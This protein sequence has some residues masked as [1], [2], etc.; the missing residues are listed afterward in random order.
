M[1]TRITILTLVVVW[2]LMFLLTSPAQGQSMAVPVDTVSAEYDSLVLPHP[3]IHPSL[4]SIHNLEGNRLSDSVDYHLSSRTLIILNHEQHYDQYFVIH[5]KP[6]SPILARPATWV[7]TQQVKSD[8]LIKSLPGGLA[9]DA[10]LPAWSSISYSGHFGRGINIGNN[11][12]TTLNSNFDLQ[13]KGSLPHGIEVVGSLSDNSI[14]IQPEGNSQR[15]QEFDKVFIQLRKDNATLIAGDHEIRNPE[16]YF[17]QYYKKTKGVFA[18]YDSTTPTGWNQQSTINY[19]VSKGK[20]KR[21]TIESEEGNQGPYRLDQT[22][23]NLFVVV[24]AGTERVYLDGRLLQRGELNDYTI[25]YNLGEITFTPRIY[26][27][28]T[29]RIIVEYEFAEQ[30]YLRSLFAGHSTWKKNNWELG[31]HVYSE[32]DGKNAYQ[33]NILT[34]ENE[35]ILAEVGDEVENLN[36]TSVVPWDGGFEEGVVLYQLIDT[37][38]FS[39]VLDLV[40]QPVDVPLYTA[41]F[42]FVG[43]GNGDYEQKGN[44]SNGEVYQWVAPDPDGSSNG[45]YAPITRLQAPQKQQMFGFDLK[46]SWGPNQENQI[47]SEWSLTNEDLN[48]FSSLDKADNVGWAQYSGFSWG[49]S[50]DSARHQ[51]FRVEGNMEW[52]NQTYQPVSN[53]RP[54]EFNR[55]WNYSAEQ[56]TVREQLYTIRATY[57]DRNFKTGYG[58]QNFD[59]DSLYSGQ[60]HELNLDWTPGSFDISLYESLTQSRTSLTGSLFSRPAATLTWHGTESG[61]LAITTGYQGE[62]NA[63]RSRDTD[64][65]SS[66]SMRFDRI[67]TTVDWK[68][69]HSLTLSSRTDYST[70]ADGFLPSF[71]TDDLQMQTGIT[72]ETGFIRWITTLRHLKVLQ[73]QSI[74]QDDQKGW[75]ILG[76]MLFAQKWFDDGWRNQGEIAVSNGKE[77]RRQFQYIK[78]ETGQ[79]QYKYVDVNNDSIQ[80]LNEFFPAIYPDE[81]NYIRVSTLENTLISTFNYKL[82]WAWNIDLAKWTTHDFWSKWSTDNSIQIENKQQRTGE[83]SLWNIPDTALVSARQNVLTNL[84]FNRNG[85]V[86]QEH[87]GYWVRKQK[88]FLHTGSESFDSQE[89]FSK[90]TLLFSNRIN[91][92]IEL[93]K[94]ITHQSATS[95]AERNFRI[96]FLQG[97]HKLRWMI[98]RT[99]QLEYKVGI[100]QG[101]EREGTTKSSTWTN[102]LSWQYKPDLKWSAH[103]TVDYSRVKF[104]SEEQNISLEQVM[105]EGLRPGGNLLWELNVQ[106]RLPNNLVV[107]LRYH[108]RKTGDASVVHTGSIQANLLF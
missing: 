80:Q 25:D 30:N 73:E 2:C 27:S 42:S 14:P 95:F 36:G 50:L 44:F 6:L 94:R 99:M 54:V 60:R 102:E 40:K 22:G 9:T 28:A 48:R 20:F 89:Y 33:N 92:F 11:Q 105:L 47:F 63:V 87:L 23:N 7:D 55:N 37:M 98:N 39:R 10:S 88:D 12:N 32:Q 93:K 66:R 84:Y 81:R 97:N 79:G 56:S 45:S 104:E 103:T 52:R 38:G 16:N 59:A 96:H 74:I 85:K 8:Y 106:R 18:G 58:Y 72:G 75:N 51:S 31:L 62:Y 19:S 69:N 82:K 29:S 90:T 17:M 21:T 43:P 35:A 46:K 77:P 91:S 5:T 1:E 71:R 13:L 34:P 86:I 101:K 65:L 68:E 15:L 64:S 61:D 70:E 108:G 26:I 76:Q 4:I 3:V 100:T 53:Y 83:L 107:S 67:Y 57:H 78:V 24:L 41:G 49:K